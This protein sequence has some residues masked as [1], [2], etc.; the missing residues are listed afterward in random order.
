MQ[1]LKLRSALEAVKIN[2]M[3]LKVWHQGLQLGT[4]GLVI[5]ERAFKLGAECGADLQVVQG[6]YRFNSKLI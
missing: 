5:H 1:A 2:I 4:V 6:E 3:W